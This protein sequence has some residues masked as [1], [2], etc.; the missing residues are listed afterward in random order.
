MLTRLLRKYV[1]MCG[2]SDKTD[3]TITNKTIH[4]SKITQCGVG[5]R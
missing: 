5:L 1:G 4:A 3:R 2:V